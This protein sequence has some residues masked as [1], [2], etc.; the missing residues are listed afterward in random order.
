MGG[1]TVL[2]SKRAK[3]DLERPRSL[4]LA[5][6][7]KP[8]NVGIGRVVGVGVEGRISVALDDK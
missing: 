7:S 1:I 8:S 6:T 5:P 4:S 2:S 3:V